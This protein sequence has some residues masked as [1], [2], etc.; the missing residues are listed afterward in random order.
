MHKASAACNA[1][2][3]T[4]GDLEV[5]AN[6]QLLSANQIV[7]ITSAPAMP[8]LTAKLTGSP[9][10]TLD[11]TLS[12]EFI[13]GNLSNDPDYSKNNVAA[14]ATWNI[15]TTIGTHFFGGKITVSLTDSDGKTC[16][17]VFYI[18]GTNP[19]ESAIKTYIGTTP[20]YAIPIA[21]Q[22]ST[23]RQFNTGT[24][25]TSSLIA[26]CPLKSNGSG[27]DW[28]IFQLSSPKPSNTQ[29]WNWKANV[30]GG[31]TKIN[32]AISIAN[33]WMNAPL[34]SPSKPAGGQRI[35]ARL[36]NNG[37]NV[38]VPVESVG[39][40]TFQ[41]GT[42]TPIED[43]VA[44]KAFNGAPNHYCSW[45]SDASK[46]LGGEWRFNRLNQNN[47]NYVSAVCSHVP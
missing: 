32:Q 34:G 7:Y 44:I 41:D 24:A 47:H 5:R 39:N 12:Q 15:N 25:S 40:V 37:V 30:D 33:F 6:N 21:K 4:N 18:R 35:Q 10:G 42:A 3:A 1:A 20:W 9:S 43:A 38:P 2:N 36:D 29:L 31:K 16:E 14:T 19:S 46:P 11:W 13:R 27:N 17:F 22:E 28:G 23:L 26:A 45:F 8:T